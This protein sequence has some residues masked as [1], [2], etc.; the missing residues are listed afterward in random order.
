MT[1]SKEFNIKNYFSIE[2]IEEFFDGLYPICKSILI[3]GFRDSIN[4]LAE[5]IL[6]MLEKF[7][8]TTDVLDWTVPDE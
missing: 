4:T 6:F 1:L 3:D 8:S 2:K 5:L 7:P